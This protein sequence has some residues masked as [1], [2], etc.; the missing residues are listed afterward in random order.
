[1]KH[2]IIMLVYYNQDLIERTLKSFQKYRYNN[3]VDIFFI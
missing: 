1:M 3:D 2:A